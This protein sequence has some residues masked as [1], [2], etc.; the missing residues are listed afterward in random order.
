MKRL[1]EGRFYLVRED[2]LTE[3][4]QKT[5]EAKRLLSSGEETTIQDAAKRLV[6][7]AVHFINIVTPYFHSSRLHENEFLRFSFNLKIVKVL[8]RHCS[9][10]SQKQNVMFLRFTKRFLFKRGQILRCHLM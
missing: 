3:S 10:S 6:Y 5:I 7:L 9:E 8:L 4:M 2:V 1:G